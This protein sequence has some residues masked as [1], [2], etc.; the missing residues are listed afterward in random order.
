MVLVDEQLLERM[1]SALEIG[2][3]EDTLAER[4]AVLNQARALI[5]LPPQR[6]TLECEE[7]AASVARTHE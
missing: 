6:H 2:I 3:R 1:V 4:Y 5:K 7:D